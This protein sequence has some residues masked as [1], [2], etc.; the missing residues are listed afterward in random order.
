MAEQFG[1]PTGVELETFAP[2]K[3]T[4]LPVLVSIQVF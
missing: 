1:S 2:W 3:P 4:A